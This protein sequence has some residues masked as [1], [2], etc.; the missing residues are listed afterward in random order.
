[1]KRVLITGGAGFIGSHTCLVL[2]Q[3][4]YE[5]FVI[6]SYIN[7]SNKS[8]ERVIK[9][10][11]DNKFSVSNKLHVIKG[12][13]RDEHILKKI[14]SD[15]SL[16]GQSIDGVIHFAGLKSV[17][18]SV[19]NPLKYWDVNVNGAINL[20]KVMDHYKCR[21]IVFSS[22]ASIYGNTYENN[23]N[24]ESEVKPINPYGTTKAVVENLLSNISLSSPGKWRIANLRYFN[25][26]GAHTSGLIG[27]DPL[28]TPNNIFPL[29][30]KVA[31]GNI[32]K[33]NIYGNDWPTPDGTGVRDY[34]HVMDVADGHE[35]AFEYLLSKEPQVLN[36]NLGTGKGTSV[37]ELI[38]TFEKVNNIKIPYVFT[39]RREGDAFRVIADNSLATC[40]LN[41]TPKRSLEDMCYDGYKWQSLN[42]NGFLYP[43]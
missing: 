4:G 12:D 26:I 25:P 6:D 24:E 11:E 30:S 42:P 5:V 32:E 36:L 29:I 27:E 39:G 13:L 35:K 7:S 23:I 40:L 33:L 38:H 28:G 2:L 14:F 9:I 21:S 22:S 20:L 41:W 18:E 8:L 34:I 43:H 19:G 31:T 10:C 3:K 15:A 17:R 16:D 1:M 37:L